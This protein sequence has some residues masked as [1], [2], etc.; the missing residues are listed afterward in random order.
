MSEPLVRVEHLSKDFG[1]D[2]TLVHAVR[3][4]TFAT[5]PGKVTLVMGPSGSG[6]TT[7]LS[8]IGGILRPTSG[9]VEIAGLELTKLGRRELPRVRR[10][11]IGFVFQTFNLLESLSTLENVE[12]ALNIAGVTGAAAEARAR[13]LLS[14]AGLEERLHFNAQALSAGERQRVALARAL[15]NEPRLVLAD[16]PTAN[17]DTEAGSQVMRLLRDLTDSKGHTA[18]VVSH[19][20][21]LK[22]VADRVLWLADGRLAPMPIAPLR[23]HDLRTPA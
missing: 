13:A 2:R 19:D 6:K 14:E 15:A 21:R 3:D 5:D 7:L 11:L 20:P 17:L 23:P 12:I 22:D 4:V 10:E 9:R 8:M 1:S 16:E 18:I